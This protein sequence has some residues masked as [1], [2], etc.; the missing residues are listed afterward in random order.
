MEKQRTCTNIVQ[1]L[2][3]SW[4][5][6]NSRPKSSKTSDYK[7][8]QSL[9]LSEVVETTQRNLLAQTDSIARVACAEPVVFRRSLPAFRPRYP[10][11][12]TPNAHA[13]G[14]PVRGRRRSN[15][16]PLGDS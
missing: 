6:S 12:V 13:L 9:G 8:R 3:W 15:C 11:L 7:R 14:E 2:K 10:N 4:R 1:V 5:D 16:G